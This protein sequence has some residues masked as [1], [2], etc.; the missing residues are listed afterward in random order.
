MVLSTAWSDANSGQ[1]LNTRIAADTT[2]NA[3]FLGGIVPTGNGYYSGGLENF[4]RF[5][6]DWSGKTFCYNG[7]MVVMFNSTIAK[8]PWGS[9]SDTY[10]PPMRM[11]AFDT[12]FYV[13]SKL[14]PSTPQ[15]LFVERLAWQTRQ[16][17]VVS[18]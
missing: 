4:P 5:L 13:E 12:N 17:G 16:P 14:P 10:S 1:P 11:W 9:N 15:I 8:A 18:P 2:V 3:A 6:E 7:A